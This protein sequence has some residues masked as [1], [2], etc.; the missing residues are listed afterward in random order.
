MSSSV[1]AGALFVGAHTSLAGEKHAAHADELTAKQ[2]TSHEHSYDRAG[3]QIA[4]HR[5]EIVDLRTALANP[6]SQT[7]DAM[8]MSADT[9]NTPSTPVLRAE[10]GEFYVL[11]SASDADRSGRH[12]ETNRAERSGM[13]EQTAR[14][15]SVP[16]DGQGR[17]KAMGRQSRDRAEQANR[18]ARAEATASADATNRNNESRWDQQRVDASPDAQVDS[19]AEH[20]EAAADEIRSTNVEFESPDGEATASADAT[21]RNTGSRWEDAADAGEADSDHT[22]NRDREANTHRDREASRGDRSYAD[23][24]DR[25]QSWHDSQSSE[26]ER[27]RSADRDRQMQQRTNDVN[28]ADLESGDQV[29]IDGRIVSRGGIQAIF[30]ENVSLRE[31]TAMATE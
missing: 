20:V 3:E 8:S 10:S 24:K 4:T 26:M 12:A 11:I 29:A 13:N 30:V 25:D 5:G 17:A 31:Q 7:G 9:G 28:V 27:N 2:H 16:R 23:S 6:Q 15:A 21:R 19:V 1:A 22:A 18:A 14:R